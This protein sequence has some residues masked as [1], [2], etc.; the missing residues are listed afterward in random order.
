MLMDNKRERLKITRTIAVHK[1]NC[2]GLLIQI[3][4]PSFLS[5]GH[6][7]NSHAFQKLK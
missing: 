7:L 3:S 1:A 6:L 2:S 4:C 5:L